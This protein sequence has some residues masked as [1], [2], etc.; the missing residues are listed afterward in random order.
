MNGEK[1]F[2]CEELSKL[3]GNL[4]LCKK[5]KKYKLLYKGRVH[6][7]KSLDDLLLFYKKHISEITTLDKSWKPV[8]EY[9]KDIE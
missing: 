3:F 2:I 9:L 7:F 5:S 4:S 8:L 6:L 1:W